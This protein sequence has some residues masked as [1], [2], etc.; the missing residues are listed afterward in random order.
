MAGVR[1][2]L[3]EVARSQVEAE[4][5]VSFEADFA[6]VKS[7]SEANIAEIRAAYEETFRDKLTARLLTMSRFGDASDTLADWLRD[8]EK[9]GR[10]TAADTS[11]ESDPTRP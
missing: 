5:R 3:L 10:I 4:L 9:Q 8:A 6:R 7:E 11:P 1:S 2:T